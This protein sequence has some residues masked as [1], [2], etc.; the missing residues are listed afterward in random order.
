ME[1]VKGGSLY[2]ILR[3]EKQF[4]DA[5]VKMIVAEIILGIQFL[6]EVVK[7]KYRDMK[8]ENILVGV[9]GHIKI[10]D[11]GLS[12]TFVNASDKSNTFAGTPEYIAPEV[13]E[14]K[15]H[16]KDVDLWGIGILL[17]ELLTGAPPFR[18]RTSK[19]LNSIWVQILKNQPVFPT[20]ISSKA[21]DL[22]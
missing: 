11:F 1:Y 4:D 21:K 3:E 18:D 19:N 12:K 22:I 10:T 13:L 7:I 17:F 9:D 14:R 15:G 8:P 6:H 20:F 2:R 5:C 16:T